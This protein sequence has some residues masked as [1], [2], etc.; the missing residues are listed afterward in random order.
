MRPSRSRAPGG[1][2]AAS[3]VIVHRVTGRMH[4]AAIEGTLAPATRHLSGGWSTTAAMTDEARLKQELEA[5][6][7]MRVVIDARLRE[8]EDRQ[9]YVVDPGAKETARADERAI[10]AEMDRVMT[11]IRAVESKLLLARAA[12]RPTTH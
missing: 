8:A 10:L 3:G 12:E 11:R 1:S 5:L 7:Q 2:G 6:D 9:R 4:F